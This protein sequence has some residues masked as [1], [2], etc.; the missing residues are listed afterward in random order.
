VLRQNPE[1]EVTD[2]VDTVPNVKQQH[3]VEVGKLSLF[4]LSFF[5]LKLVAATR[6]R[7]ESSR[8]HV[9][10]VFGTGDVGFEG[11]IGYDD[12]L[13]VLMSCYQF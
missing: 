5:L 13:L 11:I 10:D 1:P 9:H 2:F 4:F 6:F 8:Q 3:E 12:L 7:A